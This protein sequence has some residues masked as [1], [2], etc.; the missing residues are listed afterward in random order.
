MENPQNREIMAR[1][2]RIVER[3]ETPPQIEY[4]DD[5]VDY[6]L[7]VQKDVLGVFEDYKGNEFARELALGLY[8]ALEQRFAARNGRN[9]KDKPEEGEQTKMEV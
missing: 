2:Y 8:S 4:A 7:K 6:F 3:Y 1:L 5:G 9:L